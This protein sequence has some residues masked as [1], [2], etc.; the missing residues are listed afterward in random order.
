MKMRLNSMDIEFGDILRNQLFGVSFF[1]MEHHLETINVR[2]AIG[3][4][5]LLF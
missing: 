2:R 4:A 1:C 5:R 3:L